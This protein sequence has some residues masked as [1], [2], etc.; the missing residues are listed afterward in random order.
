MEIDIN[1]E[2]D[3]YMSIDSIQNMNRDISFLF[4][5]PS[6][7]GDIFIVMF[8]LIGD[9]KAE[10]QVVGR[11]GY[12]SKYCLWCMCRQSEWKKAYT[13]SHDYVNAEKWTIEKFMK[14]L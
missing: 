2:G 7:G 11:D 4:E 14:L 10:F 8:Y 6:V 5:K 1:E 9:L 12:D 3:C 13:L